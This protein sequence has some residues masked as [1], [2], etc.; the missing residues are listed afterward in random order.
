MPPNQVPDEWGHFMRTW[1]I[2]KG[3]LVS[4][5]IVDA[6]PGFAPVWERFT[7]SLDS[8]N[9]RRLPIRKEEWLSVL[10]NSGGSVY[11]GPVLGNYG[12][13]LYSLIPY[14]PAAITVAVTRAFGAPML[15]IY[16]AARLQI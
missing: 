8:L 11:T 10:H 4:T 14:L 3:K 7:P 16:Y 9:P 6:P 12:G 2:S 5:I 13:N 15:V 1:D